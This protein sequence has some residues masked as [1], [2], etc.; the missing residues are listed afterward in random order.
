MLGYS[1]QVFLINLIGAVNKYLT[2]SIS[3]KVRKQINI[4]NLRAVNAFSF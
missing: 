1:V 3:R 4:G 2:Q